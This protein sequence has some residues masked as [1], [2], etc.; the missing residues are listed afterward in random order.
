MKKNILHIATVVV[1]MLLMASCGSSRKGAVRESG[2]AV[3]AKE[4]VRPQRHN[5]DPGFDVNSKL[6]DK[7]VS[8]ARKWIGT[9]Y[10]Y[11]GESRKGTDCSGMTMSIF[12]DVAGVAIPRNSARQ[13][14]YCVSIGRN[15]LQP[16]DLVFFSSKAGSGAVS[17][18]GIYVGD[19]KM[20]HA[21]ASRGVMESCLDDRYWL[22]HYYG[23]GRVDGVTYAMTGRKSSKKRGRKEAPAEAVPA[24]EEE[25]LQIEYAGAEPV[26][27]TVIPEQAELPVEETVAEL[28]TENDT[29]KTVGETIAATE[30]ELPQPEEEDAEPEPTSDEI[31]DEVKAAF[32]F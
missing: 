25:I 17:H 7:I 10:K 32:S 23:S 18:V 14:E 21:S 3:E 4:R 22:T 1:V 27:D 30:A 11:G 20:I 24:V 13:F 28:P 5:G 6:A 26:M 29:D 19:R 2:A 31:N 16:G 12:K 8:H 9:P 15:D